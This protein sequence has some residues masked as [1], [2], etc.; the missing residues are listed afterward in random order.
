MQFY[1]SSSQASSQY[2]GVTLPLGPH[3]GLIELIASDDRGLKY[4]EVLGLGEPLF[5]SATGSH[6]LKQ[7]ASDRRD[8]VR[9][10]RT[11]GGLKIRYAGVVVLPAREGV[12]R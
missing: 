4:A 9:L 6:L 11:L 8:K 7:V 10:R 3:S 2:P 5:R 1:G 12:S